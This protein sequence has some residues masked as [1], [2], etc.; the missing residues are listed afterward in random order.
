MEIT[1]INRAYLENG[2]LKVSI[3]DRGSAWLNTGT[4]ASLKQASLLVEFIEERQ[5]LNIGGIEKIVHAN[6]YILKAQ[7][8]ILAKPLLNVKTWL[9][10]I[11]TEFNI[12]CNN[13]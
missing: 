10:Q 7:L 6:G 13:H 9:W 12:N 3:L 5:G 8:H 4:F 2:K 1:D 11:L